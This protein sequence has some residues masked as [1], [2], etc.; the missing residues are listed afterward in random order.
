MEMNYVII[1]KIVNEECSWQGELVDEKK[2]G[3]PYPKY[4]T[5]S[6]IFDS[7]SDTLSNYLQVVEDLTNTK[8]TK[9]IAEGV[10]TDAQ[11]LFL[12]EHNCHAIQGYYFYQPL[13]ATE[14]E[15]L[16]TVRVPFSES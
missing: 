8:I 15:R 13:S 9:V 10:E 3:T 12:K 6:K 14:F 1:W 5:I 11:Y 7:K 4:M 16:I 2:D